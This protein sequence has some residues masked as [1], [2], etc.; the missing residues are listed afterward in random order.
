MEN[1]RLGEISCWDSGRRSKNQHEET[2]GNET[3]LE[4]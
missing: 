3:S 4:R 1:V 2:G